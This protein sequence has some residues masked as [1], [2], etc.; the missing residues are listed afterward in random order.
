MRK[1]ENQFTHPWG[2][3][4]KEKLKAMWESGIPMR[5]INEKL[6][7]RSKGA[8]QSKVAKMGWRRP[9]NKKEN[10]MGHLLKEIQE[11]GKIKRPKTN[12][13]IPKTKLQ[14]IFLFA[15]SHIPF[16]DNKIIELILNFLADEHPDI[17][18]IG[19]DFLDF[20][21]ISKFRK[22]PLSIS[23]IES[24]LDEAHE[25]LIKI[26][27]SVPK[28]RIFYI[29]GNHEFRWRSY[30]IEN[31]P[32]FYELFSLRF[33]DLLML[34]KLN[35]T[36]IPCPP[37]LNK[38]SHNF[39]QINDFCIGHF[40]KALK[41]ACYS[42]RML[43]DEFGTNIIQFHVHRI[44]SS[45]RTYVDKTKFGAEIGCTCKLNPAYQRKPDWQ[46]GIGM[47]YI[48]GKNSSFYNIAIKNSSFIFSDKQ[49]K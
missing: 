42:G 5:E 11:A 18:I 21:Q 7:G 32:I 23:N 2:K 27:E 33:T 8:I 44:G 47:L 31:A 6:S 37:E 29:E 43:R 26:R 30:L 14:K 41:N 35:I 12:I 20:Y 46:Q 13:E 22:N 24:D 17:I 16:Q 10:Q 4:E 38:F 28:S 39:L 36:Y 15:D 3:E 48:K 25:I 1:S 40:D 49:Y 45:Y 34:E 19:G 9:Q